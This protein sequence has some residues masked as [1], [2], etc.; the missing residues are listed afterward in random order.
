MAE[1]SW[2]VLGLSLSSTYISLM[3]TYSIFPIFYVDDGHY[4]LAQEEPSASRTNPNG[5]SE[6]FLTWGNNNEYF[7]PLSSRLVIF[8]ISFSPDSKATMIENPNFAFLTHDWPKM[9]PGI[10]LKTST[11]LT[12]P[13]IGGPVI[14]NASIQLVEVLNP[15]QATGIRDM[16]IGTSKVT[17]PFSPN[18]NGQHAQFLI[19]SDIKVG[20]YLVNV[21]A[22]FDNPNV[23]AIYAGKAFIQ[24]VPVQSNAPPSNNMVGTPNNV[25]S[26]LSTSNTID[27]GA[28]CGAGEIRGPNGNCIVEVRGDGGRGG[29]I[30]A[31][32]CT[33]TDCEE[34]DREIEQESD[35]DS[36]DIAASYD[37]P[38]NNDEN[39][40]DES[41]RDENN[42][43]D[44]S[45]NDND[46]DNESAPSDENGDNQNGGGNGN[47]LLE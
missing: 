13:N 45:D 42:N 10:V 4:A 28:N 27:G 21:Y 3:V 17:L 6:L 5:I 47:D 18:D 36:A 37:G 31:E 39:S 34:I 8:P 38:T 19:P 7:Q 25:G 46:N 2:L 30:N 20:H 32:N 43:E 16:Q 35:D 12:N 11:A 29:V 23:I 14:K 40:N 1:K 9:G 26:R 41:G 24:N 33:G 22:E 44:N 15:N